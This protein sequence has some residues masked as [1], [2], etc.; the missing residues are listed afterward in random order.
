MQKLSSDEMITLSCT[1]S[2]QSR[3]NQWQERAMLVTNKRL[4][5]IEAKKQTYTF[6]RE[7]I[8]SQIESIIKS[9]NE[10]CGDDLVVKVKDDYDYRFK[11]KKRE[12]LKRAL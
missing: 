3:F 4:I 12:E 7:I 8:I 1:I 10:K 9:L 2:K 6:K 5:N 11:C